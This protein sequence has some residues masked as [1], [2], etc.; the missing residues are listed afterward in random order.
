M[1]KSYWKT[2]SSKITKRRKQ[3]GETIIDDLVK[4]LTVKYGNGC[5]KV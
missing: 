1:S 2:D 3:Y 5:G 4:Q